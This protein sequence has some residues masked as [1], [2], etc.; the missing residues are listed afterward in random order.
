[1][2]M[3]HVLVRC[4]TAVTAWSGVDCIQAQLRIIH[5]FVAHGPDVFRVLGIP[6]AARFLLSGYVS[7]FLYH[8]FGGSLG[9]LYGTPTPEN[10][11]TG[12]RRAPERH[13][14]GARRAPVTGLL[15]CLREPC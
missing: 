5:V 15:M 7:S 13:V 6:R 8:A 1:M 2:L 14:T 11:I 3:L 10:A 9:H 12:A 4:I